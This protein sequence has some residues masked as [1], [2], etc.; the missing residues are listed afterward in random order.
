MK[1]ALTLFAICLSLVLGL[2]MGVTVA[3]NAGARQFTV[4][5]EFAVRDRFPG[6]TLVDSGTAYRTCENGFEVRR[7]PD[8]RA[9]YF[10]GRNCWR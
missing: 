10:P 3:S 8:G 4:V 9:L 2:A 7:Y 5:E 1:T 6:G